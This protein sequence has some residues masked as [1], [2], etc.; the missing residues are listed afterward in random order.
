[1]IVLASAS[2]RRAEWLERIGV[3][4]LVRPVAIDESPRPDE[5]VAAY[6]L[7]LAREKA[8]AAVTDGIVLAADTAVWQDGRI[9]GK[10]RDERDGI[11]T[12]LALSGREHQVFTGLHVRSADREA[13]RLASATVTFRSIDPAEA[14][15]Y[16]RTGEPADKAGGY[17]MQGMGGVFVSRIDGSPGAVVGLP[18]RE[19]HDVL[20]SFGV[21]CWSAPPTRTA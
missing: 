6:V 4:F 19:T 8:A 18:L 3:P 13:C 7:R 10:P 15:A 17:G 5:P 12:L 16:W 11:A 1:M 2:P 21:S 9:F 20:R 14:A